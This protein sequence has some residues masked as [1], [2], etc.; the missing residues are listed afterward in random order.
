[1]RATSK[2]PPNCRGRCLVN[3][4]AAREKPLLVTTH[5]HTFHGRD[6]RLS[7]ILQALAKILQVP[8]L[9]GT[10]GIKPRYL[11]DIGSGWPPHQLGLAQ[12]TAHHSPQKNVLLP[13]TTTARTAL[14]ACA[15]AIFSKNSPMSSC[16]RALR[17]LGRLKESTRTPSTGVDAVTS[18]SLMAQWGQSANV[19]ARSC[20]LVVADVD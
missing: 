6:D 5:R 16:E 3:L 9:P 17:L 1:M 20:G 7:D 12:K 8:T 11:L 10:L 2:P 18:V 4:N 19:Y 13:V 15:A 14:S